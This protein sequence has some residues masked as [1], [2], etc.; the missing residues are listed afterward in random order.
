MKMFGE[1][2]DKK[3]GPEYLE[4]ITDIKT[5]VNYGK[6]SS[7]VISN[8]PDWEGKEGETLF[9]YQVNGTGWFYYNYFWV[10]SGWSFLRWAGSS[11]A[12]VPDAGSITTD[13]IQ[14]GAVTANELSAN[15]VRTAGYYVGNSVQGHAIAHGLGR[16]PSFVM[17]WAV[18]TGSADGFE[19]IIGMGAKVRDMGG[20]TRATTSIPDATYFYTPGTGNIGNQDG[21][22]Y[23]WVAL[24]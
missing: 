13:M 15:A 16:A 14:T 9:R 17:S 8:A 7:Q 5:L 6:Y 4:L 1:Y 24:G 3:L 18:D 11:N 20:T 19:Y 2:E 21:V 23:Y 22:T 10:N 12:L